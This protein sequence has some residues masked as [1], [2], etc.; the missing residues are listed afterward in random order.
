M[1]VDL[2]QHIQP[3]PDLTS[4]SRNDA[5]TR[6]NPKL[7]PDVVLD[8]LNAFT[9]AVL[10]R[11]NYYDDIMVEERPRIRIPAAAASNEVERRIRRPASILVL[12]ISG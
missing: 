11:P 12:F 3:P 2:T 5:G 10:D 9:G 1:V 4:R 8:G 6:L 7:Q